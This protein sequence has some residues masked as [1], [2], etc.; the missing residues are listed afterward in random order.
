MT[1]SIQQRVSL[2][3]LGL[4]IPT[5]RGFWL[6]WVAEIVTLVSHRGFSPLP[7][8]DEAVLANIRTYLI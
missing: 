3:Q 7:L 5:G 4:P 6:G 2:R 8:Y 1:F